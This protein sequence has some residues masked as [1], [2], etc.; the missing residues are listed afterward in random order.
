MEANGGLL[1]RHSEIILTFDNLFTNFTRLLRSDDKINFKGVLLN[2]HD[3]YNIG[4]RN[5]NIKGYELKCI[6]CKEARGAVSSRTPS[7]SK[8]SELFRTIV[9]DCVV[10]AKY[11]LNFLLNPIVVI[12]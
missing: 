11:I 12:K 5:L 4:H 7:P 1:K 2:D 9:N 3:S 8:L 6:E 10:S